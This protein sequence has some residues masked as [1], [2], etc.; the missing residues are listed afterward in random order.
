M[1]SGGLDS[2]SIAAAASH[3]HGLRRPDSP[4][5][6][7]AYT[8]LWRDGADERRLSRLAADRAGLRISPVYLDDV[9]IEPT[10]AIAF[11]HETPL[12]NPIDLVH[13]HLYRIAAADG[14]KI[15]LSGEWG[16]DLLHGGAFLADLLRSGRWKEFWKHVIGF[17]KQEAVPIH[18]MLYHLLGFLLLPRRDTPK[19]PLHAQEQVYEAVFVPLKLMAMENMERG[20]AA[21]GIDL[22]LPFLDLRIVEFLFRIP[23]ELLADEGVGKQLLRKGLADLLPEEIARRTLKDNTP[24]FRPPPGAGGGRDGNLSAFLSDWTERELREWKSA[25]FGV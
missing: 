10:A 6:V 22:R 14:H 11:Q 2:P 13:D 20:A 16:D 23:G 18:A 5:L 7:D 12:L 8:M 9:N 19:F 4:L 25:W 21:Y 17:R 3:T 24:L 1:L 15:L